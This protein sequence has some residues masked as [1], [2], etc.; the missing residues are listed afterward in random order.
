MSV[1]HELFDLSGKV[2]IIT[3]GAGGIGVV[4]ADA[5]AQAGRPSSWPT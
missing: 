4:Y 3:G 2:A 5:L 1:S